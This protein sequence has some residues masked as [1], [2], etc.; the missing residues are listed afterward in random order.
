M[1]ARKISEAL[2]NIDSR[3]LT[4]VLDYRPSYRKRRRI[5]TALAACLCVAVLLAAALPLLLDLTP[6]SRTPVSP[7]EASGDASGTPQVF[8]DGVCY[9]ES[10]YQ[11]VSRECPSGFS[12]GGVIS[13]GE[14]KGCEYYVNPDIPEWVY[15]YHEVYLRF[16][17]TAIRGKS[18]ISY[19]GQLYLSMWNAAY[20]DTLEEIY[21]KI[22]SQYG[23]RIEGKPPKG[24]FLAGPAVFSGLDTIPNGE[25]SSNQ[26]GVT[27]YVNPDVP[28][29]VLVSAFWYTATREEGKETRHT[30]FDVYVRYDLP[31]QQ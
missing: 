18:M 9:V 25:L 2:G 11:I 27:V 21:E 13:S 26:E 5:W 28:E 3:Y 10:S 31:S 29:I 22:D 15:V 16:V 1:N 12:L 23:I 7:G 19:Q 14:L 8:I 30:G 20:D 24:F 6:S 4:E 17:D